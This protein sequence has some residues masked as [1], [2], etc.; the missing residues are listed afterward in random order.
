[1]TTMYSATASGDQPLN[2]K[3]CSL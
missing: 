1:M 2:K 3:I